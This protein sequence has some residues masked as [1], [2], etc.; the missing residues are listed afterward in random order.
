[1]TDGTFSLVTSICTIGGLAGSLFANLIMDKWGRRG[2][3]R[4][5]ATLMASGT[6][7]M[8]LGNSV[9]MLLIGRFLIGLASGLGIC[10]SPIYLAEIAPSNISGSV[11]VL[12]QFALVFGIMFTQVAGIALATPS[13]WR[14]VFF[15]SFMISVLQ[16]LFSSTIVESPTWL[17]NQSRLDEHKHAVTRLWGNDVSEE[18]LLNPFNETREVLPQKSLTVPQVFAATGLRKPLMIVSLVMIAQQVSGIN[19]VLYYSNDILAKSLP[20]FG[21]Y[22]SFSI[23]V[24]N[25]IMTFP[26]IMLVQRLGTVRLLKISALGSLVSLFAVGWGLNSGWSVVPSVA[27]V[28]FVMSYAVGLGP[29]PFCVIPEVS[30][31][32]AVS[33]LAS[34]ALSLN[35]MTNFGVGLVFL[36][37]RNYLSGG[38]MLKEGRVF[39]IFVAV[40][41]LS[42]L[43][44]FKM[45]K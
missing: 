12:I 36:P 32:Y 20:R 3:H 8:G 39:Y 4:I 41:S 26:P 44:L 10:V 37:M 45:Y 38:D 27:I 31:P 7:F 21:P 42:T 16:L 28:I 5:S 2:A 24:I 25:V 40:L 15:I 35:W 9:S 30:P 29:I 23:T 33:S 34:V 43:F 14:F 13:N 18:P 22:I 17:F 19:A 11:G 1:M 6:A